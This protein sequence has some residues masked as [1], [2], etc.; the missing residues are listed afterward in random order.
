MDLDVKGGVVIAQLRVAPQAVSASDQHPQEH[1]RRMSL[2]GRDYCESRKRRL[3][4]IVHRLSRGVLLTIR[5]ARATIVLLVV[6]VWTIVTIGIC[7]NG[8]L[9]VIITRFGLTGLGR[10]SGSPAR[11]RQSGNSTRRHPS[12]RTRSPRWSRPRCCLRRPINARRGDARAVST[13][14]TR[15]STHMQRLPIWQMLSDA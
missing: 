12:R 14:L 2:P 1:R 11:T 13:L 7:R 4:K 10:S 9:I 6:R 3:R 8:M 15:T 5:H